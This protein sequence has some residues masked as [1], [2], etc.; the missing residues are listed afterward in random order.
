VLAAR[1]RGAGAKTVHARVGR[2]ISHFTINTGFFWNGSQWIRSSCIYYIYE[3]KKIKKIYI[4]F[5][6]LDLCIKFQC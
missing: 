2:V 5:I 6:I 4:F 1:R 3:L